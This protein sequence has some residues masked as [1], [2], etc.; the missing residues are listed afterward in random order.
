M[1]ALRIS[2]ALGLAASI[3]LSYIAQTSSKG[4]KTSVIRSAATVTT[5]RLSNALPSEPAIS[6][7][8]SP[9]GVQVKAQALDAKSES[10]IMIS[11]L[12]DRRLLMSDKTAG[13]HVSAD[14]ALFQIPYVHVP[15]K[16]I[17]AP[18]ADPKDL[19]PTLPFTYLGKQK[20]EGQWRVFL[21]KEG[22]TMVVKQ[23]DVVDAVYQVQSIAPPTLT[24]I[25][26]PRGETQ[27]MEIGSSTE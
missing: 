26:L 5:A 6:A 20:Q 16:P 21:E 2:L 24:L 12:I 22:S 11:K 15:R 14:R 19:I 25:Y 3:Y 18:A 9:V 4:D 7:G 23:D 8:T 10:E 13:R 17:S 27:T 1:S